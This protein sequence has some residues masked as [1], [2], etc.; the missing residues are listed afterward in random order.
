MV[1]VDGR[2]DMTNVLSHSI[3]TGN[4]KPVV[5][6]P[7]PLSPYIQKEVDAKLDRMIKLDVIEQAQN[8]WSNPIVSLRRPNGKK[9]VF[10]RTGAKRRYN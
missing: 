4:A 7:Y 1:T 9:I 6:R 10:R 5:K 3:D 8:D 2:I